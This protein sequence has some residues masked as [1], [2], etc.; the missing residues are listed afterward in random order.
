[1]PNPAWCSRLKLLLV[2]TSQYAP[3][4]PL[5]LEAAQS[6]PGLEVTLVD[7]KEFFAP[8]ATSLPHRA[9]YRLLGRR[10][11]RLRAFERT[12]META[13]ATRP[14]VVLVVKGPYV[15]PNILRRLRRMGAVLVN[16]STDDPFSPVAKFPHLRET[17]R[18]YDVYA[19][20]RTANLAQ[21]KAHGARKTVV[22]PFGYKPTVHFVDEMAAP[23][24]NSTDVV[25]IGGADA[26]RIAFFRRVVAIWPGVRLDLY[27]NYW[28]R[29]AVLRRFWR[30][31]A[32]GDL[33]RA[34]TRRATAAINLVRQCN[35]D[36]HVMRSFEVPACGG[37]MVAE[38][39]PDHASFFDDGREA[40]FFDTP[41]EL[42]HH[43]RM[44]A[45]DRG[46]RDAV[47]A[48]GHARVIR[49][50]HTDRDRL[51]TLLSACA[52]H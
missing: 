26:D 15:R 39:T 6:V 9:L 12:L 13:E 30:G 52:P 4:S 20:P 49:D 8:I 5:F 47:V 7:E 22:I 31:F 38:R 2:E 45:S 40:L 14:D 43:A 36:G 33:Y 41:E 44:L 11:P 25:F 48:A 34:A 27:G 3:A 37:C 10:P 24:V 46:R 29:D 17:I 50:R 32:Y 19:T 1:L 21:L 28:N 18:D 35:R 51:E 23:G 16:F 42:V